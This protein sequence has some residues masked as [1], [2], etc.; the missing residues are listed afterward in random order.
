M[1]SAAAALVFSL[2]LV[3]QASAARPPT[4]AE[5]TALVHG[6]AAYFLGDRTTA[7]IRYVQIR[8]SSVDPRWATVFV[9]RWDATGHQLQSG[10]FVWHYVN[11]R[12][13]L[14]DVGDAALGCRVPAAVRRDLDLTCPSTLPKLFG[15]FRPVMVWTTGDGSAAAGGPDGDGR[16]SFGHI[17]WVSWTGTTAVGLAVTWVRRPLPCVYAHRTCPHH[18]YGYYK[19]ESRRQ[20][21]LVAT[22]PVAG[23][24]RH[25]RWG[26]FCL[27]T[28]GYRGDYGGGLVYVSCRTW[29]PT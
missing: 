23:E 14:K 1:R 10:T 2:T 11:G 9:R 8:V 28:H 19:L 29:R 27:L 16:K 7:R 5:R 13:T 15:N 12:W 24:F 4:A 6:T 3:V 22:K 21:R 17:R 26:K 20:V 25:L 18:I